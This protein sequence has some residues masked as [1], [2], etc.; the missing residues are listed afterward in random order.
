MMMLTL[1]L[2]AVLQLPFQ[3]SDAVIGVAAVHLESGRRFA[4]RSTERFPMGSVYKVPIALE[5]LRRVDAG[6]VKLDRVVT[7]EPKDFSPGWSP[8]REAAKGKPV[9][10]TIERLLWNLVA[11]SDNTASDYFLRMVGPDSVTQLMKTLGVPGIRIDRQEREIAADLKKKGG[12]EHY[13][14]DIRDTSTPDEML[15][16]MVAIAQRRD[17]LSRASHDH[18]V[19]WMTE[20][21]TGLKRIKAGV[22]KG[23][24][25]AHKTGTMPGTMNDVGILT[26]P[27]GKHHVAIAIFTKRAAKSKDK[28]V[29]AD[30]AA[31]AAKVYGELVR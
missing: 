29:E 17:G 14:I 28:D 31:A 15:A 30:I 11:V 19:Q 6:T 1:V 24:T 26:S 5:V 3:K 23:T 12:V 10:M 7:I 25:V 2:A 8:I 22:P 27:D 4:V 9:S 18:L 21:K 20:T 16:L 13:A